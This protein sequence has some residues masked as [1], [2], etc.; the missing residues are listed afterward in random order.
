MVAVGRFEWE[1]RVRE[2]DLPG[3][4]KL[5][6][7]VLGTYMNGDGSGARPTLVTLAKNMGTSDR[8]ARRRVD[9]LIGSGYLE[10]VRRGHRLGN[11][12]G[13]AS[14]YRA[15]APAQPDTPDRLSDASTG[16]PCP[17]EDIST[18]Q[19]VHLN[20]TTAA[21]QPV[22]G[23]HL[24]DPLDQTTSTTPA[25][26]A[27]GAVHLHAVRVVRAEGDSSIQNPIAVARH[28]VE[29]GYFADEEQELATLAEHNPTV[30]TGDLFDVWQQQRL[31][32]ERLAQERALREQEAARTKAARIAA[33][34]TCDSYG[35]RY[36]EVLNAATTCDHGPQLR[37][38]A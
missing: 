24:P 33:C 31:K 36:D 28:R 23:V 19:P 13:V 21:P 18:G 14:E 10:R 20:R 38:S 29:N 4:D 6:A 7:L 37:R 22:T 2:S 8:T 17:V 34:D 25:Q 1:R 11:G 15:A 30:A 16:H 3:V 26:R 5:C 32:Q 12:T 35:R 27:R 9:A